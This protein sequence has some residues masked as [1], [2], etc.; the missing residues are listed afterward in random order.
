MRRIAYLFLLFAGICW[1][2]GSQ[3]ADKLVPPMVK[4]DVPAIK[5]DVPAI[6]VEMPPQN[7]P[8]IW[9]QLGPSTIGALV[10]VIVVLLTSWLARKT[11]EAQTR[12]TV[13]KD[14]YVKVLNE[15]GELRHLC[16][17]I[18][19]EMVVSGGTYSDG[20]QTD[21]K[22]KKLSD[23]ILLLDQSVGVSRLFMPIH[24]LEALRNAVEGFRG[25]YVAFSAGKDSIRASPNLDESLRTLD[26][27]RDLFLEIATRDLKITA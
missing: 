14:N 20:D 25:V 6:K 3:Q 7:P 12:L 23:D 9:S 24:A 21:L 15:I 5:L 26:N 17:T 2:Q 1:P 13:R 4:V 16:Q 10:A 8:N 18:W 11:W 22:V 19:S 27:L